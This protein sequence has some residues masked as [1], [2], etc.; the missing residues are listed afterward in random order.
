MIAF[1]KR[2]LKLYL[3]DR[4][5]VMFSL[6]AVFI[7]IG[8]YIL[9]LRDVWTDSFNAFSNSREIINNWVMSGVLAI[10]SVTTTLGMLGTLVTDKEDKIVKDFYVAPINRTLLAGGYMISAY[11]VGVVMSI[12]AFII[13]EIYIVADGGAMLSFMGIIKV[14]G[15]ILVTTFMNT[16]LMLFMVSLFNSRNAFSTAS[17]IIG[18]LIGFVTGIYLPIGSFPDAVQMVIKCFPV[19]HAALVFKTIMMEQPLATALDSIPD[20]IGVELKTQLGVTFEYGSYTMPVWG[21][22][23]VILITG[24]VFFILSC[25]TVLKKTK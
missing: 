5:A 12:I 23:L 1:A 18:T 9:F 17:T 10:T 7:V 13:A 4:S 21:C 22:I 25:K 20:S 15:M 14:L 8:L 11:F 2:N 6:L 19:S 16:A 3:R 24:T